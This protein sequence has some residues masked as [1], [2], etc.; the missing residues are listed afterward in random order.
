MEVCDGAPERDFG[1]ALLGVVDAR[2]VDLLDVGVPDDFPVVKE[3][4]VRL[5]VHLLDLQRLVCVRSRLVSPLRPRYPLYELQGFE[6]LHLVADRPR[7]SVDP[8]G[9]FLAFYRRLVLPVEID[10]LLEDV[11]L[12]RRQFD[13]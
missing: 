9:D 11:L 3:R 8:V 12:T 1:P 13:G 7:V 10:Q 4:D 5:V 2:Q 6:A